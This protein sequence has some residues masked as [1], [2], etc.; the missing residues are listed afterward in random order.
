MMKRLFYPCA[1]LLFLPLILWA[2]PK[3]EGGIFLGISNYQG[4]MVLKASPTFK[5]ANL[6]FGL[7]GRRHLGMKWALRGNAYYGKLSGDDMNYKEREKRAVKFKTSLFEVSIM[8]EWEPWGDRRYRAADQFNKLVSPYLFFGTG[9]AWTNPKPDFS[10]YPGDG[11]QDEIQKDKE[12]SKSNK[13][14]LII[15]LGLGLKIDVDRQWLFGLELGMR[16]PFTDNVDG[17]SHI[18]NPDKNDWYLF[19]GSS[20]SY[21]F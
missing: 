6:G 3:W 11:L 17:I 16:Y 18:G 20:L 14:H 15:P 7:L 9:I 12:A 2:Q 10:R 8:A 5:E 21:R 4:D 1:V 19:G 13:S